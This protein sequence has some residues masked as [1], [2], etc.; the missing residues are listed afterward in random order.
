MKTRLTFALVVIVSI[1][2]GN[3]QQ[4]TAQN[5]PPF[6]SLAGNNN[7]TSTS[8]LGTL[9]NVP[10]S[11]YANGNEG[12]RISTNGNV[13]IGTKTPGFK[14]DVAG[15]MR[16]QSGSG[17]ATAGTWLNNAANTNTA[18][19]V[20]MFND[21]NIGLFGNSGAGWGFL[22]NTANGNVGIGTSSPG[23]KLDVAG[24]MRIRS[25]SGTN[26]AGT[27]FMNAANTADAAFVGLVNDNN[28]GFFG[29][30]IGWAFV[31]NLSNG[32]VG[33]GNAAPASRLDI[34]DPGIRTRS[35]GTN[36]TAIMATATGS[37]GQAVHAISSNSFGI[38]AETQNSL[39]FA[40]FF[41]GN[42]FSTGNYSGSDS[43]LKQNI[44]EFT[45]AMSLINKLQPKAYEYRHD[46]NFKLMNLPAGKHY[47]LIAQDVEQVLPNLV[48]ETEFNT[49]GAA[50]D[51]IIT[52]TSD[53]SGAT[54]GEIINF[55]A[56]NYTELIPVIIKGMQ[57]LSKQNEEL[58]KQLKE[59]KAAK[60]TSS[61]GDVSAQSA[62]KIML[63]NA[64]IGQNSP[65]PFAG[66]TSIRYNLPAGFKVAQIVIKD[67]NGKTIKQVQLSTTTGEGTVN[68][69]A[70]TL[71]SGTYN[72]TLLVDGKV[73]EN[74]KM[75]VAH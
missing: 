32:N 13:G 9:N 69:D 62:T 34:G 3:L 36:G 24:R 5:T 23:F 60:I 67:N 49:A 48:K 55:K 33:I 28:V 20:G 45:N 19:F 56:M 35:T 18:G 73:I 29:N 11:V 47:G 53:Q 14:L 42:V 31:M 71:G 51:R 54:K 25:G 2:T 46:G 59:L 21:N 66:T 22:M 43:K 26:T 57:E 30:H 61:P 1:T 41:S 50:S 39:S 63:T 38:F 12:M 72:Y 68:I 6:W 52:S 58:Q 10:L 64:S 70:S 15:R 4:A 74:K 40:G 16:I 8:K 7:A 65:N 17:V 75:I 37:G 27:W 44:Q